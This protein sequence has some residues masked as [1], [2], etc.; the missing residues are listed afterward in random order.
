M[1]WLKD[2]QQ[3][4]MLTVLQCLYNARLH[5]SL[6]VFSTLKSKTCTEYTILVVYNLH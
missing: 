3:N 1:I 6:N 4:G 2:L 5:E